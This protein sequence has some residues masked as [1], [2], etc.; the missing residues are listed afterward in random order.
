M[1]I[2]FNGF[3]RRIALAGLILASAARVVMAQ[4]LSD[5]LPEL[6]TLPAPPSIGW[7]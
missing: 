2:R 4:D 1:K 6:K 5:V 7:R 3:R